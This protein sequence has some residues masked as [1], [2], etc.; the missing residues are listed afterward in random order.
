MWAIAP[1]PTVI[2]LLVL[3]FMGA[4]V[5]AVAGFGGGMLFL[6]FLT[7]LV[8]P[9]RAVPIITVTLLFATPS[10]A[11][12]NRRHLRWRIIGWFA[13]GCSFGAVLGA[14]VFLSLPVFWLLKAI[15]AFLI[16][17]VIARRV[18]G[19]K[20]QI[21]DARAFIV[22]GAAGGFVGGVVGGMGPMVSPF[23]LAAGLTGP[24]FVGTIAASGVWMHIVK[25]VVYGRGGAFDA[26][27]LGLGVALGLAMVVGTLIGS[28]VLRR[29]DTAGFKR[30]V[31]ILL[32]MIGVWFLVGAG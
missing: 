12:I 9:E 25:L 30:I 23:F 21:T 10:R 16:L 24:A 7:A 31:E 6:P 3:S 5:S 28:T 11:F 8:G 20:L 4:V 22:I 17:A 14:L 32:T 29:L 19:A 1:S 27:A 15:G 26:G 13:L 2:V 18:P